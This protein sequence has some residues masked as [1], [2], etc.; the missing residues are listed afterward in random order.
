MGEE[1]DM[2]T[3]LGLFAAI[4]CAA[5]AAVASTAGA[6]G[7]G[8]GAAVIRDDG[9]TCLTSDGTSSWLFSCRIHIV[10]EPSG[11]I[12]QYVTGS[13][14]TADSDPLPASAAR[15]ITTADTGIPCL[16]LNNVVITS[17]VSGV[18][19]PNGRVML[20]CRS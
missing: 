15:D 3:R 20:T 13:V 9:G 12:T 8:S 14:D 18:V 16:V 7:P 10:I 19:T 4:C 1:R 17:V 11:A 5:V 2:R 6:T